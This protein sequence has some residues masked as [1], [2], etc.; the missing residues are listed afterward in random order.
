MQS[1]PI[2]C[3]ALDVM[4]RHRRSSRWL[5]VEFLVRIK[6]AFTVTID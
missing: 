2:D 3:S 5:A 6:K 1:P 4:R